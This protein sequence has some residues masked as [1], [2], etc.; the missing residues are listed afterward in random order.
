MQFPPPSLSS[1]PGECMV[2][3]LKDPVFNTS[4]IV[5]YYWIPLCIL[6]V[7]YSFIFEAAWRLSKKSADKE[8][9]RKEGRRKG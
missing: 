8:K 3:F 1:R 9:G 5:G 6:C 2:Q 7:L 4:L